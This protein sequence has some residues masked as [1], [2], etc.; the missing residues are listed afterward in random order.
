M[1]DGIVLRVGVTYQYCAG[2]RKPKGVVVEHGDERVVVVTHEEKTHIVFNN[3][4][5]V[6]DKVF[7]FQDAKL[8]AC[9]LRLIIT[10]LSRILLEQN[11]NGRFTMI[12]EFL[13]KVRLIDYSIVA[14]THHRTY[15]PHGKHFYRRGHWRHRNGVPYWVRGHEVVR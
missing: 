4:T 11:L 5:V 10:Q 7:P 8:G 1:I 15:I 6:L 13:F 3:T 12:I 2:I 9:D 14:E